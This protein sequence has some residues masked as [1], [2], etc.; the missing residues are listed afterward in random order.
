MYFMFL[1]VQILTVLLMSVPSP[2]AEA[3]GP[4]WIWAT[5]PEAETDSGDEGTVILTARVVFHK[6]GR[7][8]PQTPR[9]V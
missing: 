6:Q 4:L 8:S 3:L 1:R 2:S 9:K 7:V 5:G